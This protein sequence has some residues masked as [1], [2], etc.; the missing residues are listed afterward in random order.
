MTCERVP[1]DTLV[2]RVGV[3]MEERQRDRTRAASPLQAAPGAVELDTTGLD[4]DQVVA[5]ITELLP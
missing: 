5:R 1:H 4:I 2:G 3:R